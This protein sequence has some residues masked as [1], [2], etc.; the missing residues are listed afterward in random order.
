VKQKVLLII[1][2]F[3]LVLPVLASEDLTEETVLQKAAEK[4]EKNEQIALNYGFKLET[5]IQKM[6]GDGKLEKEIKRDSNIIWLEGKPYNELLTING[7]KPDSS[8]MAEEAKRKREFIKAIRENKKILRE[9]LTW[10]DL[11][12][13]YDFAFLPA[14]QGIPYVISFKPKEG[15]LPERNVIE[16][17]F[18]YLA[19]KAWIDEKFNLVKAEAWL[20]QSIRFGFGIFGKIEGIHFTYSQEEFQQVWL[21]RAF[22]L[23]YK[24]RRFVFNDNQDITTRFYDFYPR[25]NWNQTEPAGSQSQ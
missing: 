14:D 17:V 10:K 7:Q 16:K 1:F 24:A 2:L 25:P 13:K 15:K 6:D 23:R 22:H 18:N 20:T 5:I 8:Q 11:F 21:P 19:G 12:K 4:A 9:S 3:A